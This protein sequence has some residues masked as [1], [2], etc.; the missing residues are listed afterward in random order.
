MISSKTGDCVELLCISELTVGVKSN[1]ISLSTFN[2]DD[3]EKEEEEEEEEEEGGGG[4][5]GGGGGEIG[6]RREGEGRLN[7]AITR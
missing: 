4:G 5:G 6:T 3:D 1:E 7:E 2:D